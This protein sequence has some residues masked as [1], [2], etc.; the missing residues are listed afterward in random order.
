MHFLLCLYC[1][2]SLDELARLPNDF[3]RKG[4]KPHERE[5]VWRFPSF[6]LLSHMKED[7]LV[8]RIAIGEIPCYLIAQEQCLVGEG[9]HCNLA[10]LLYLPASASFCNLLGH[11][12]IF[13]KKETKP[14]YILSG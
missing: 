14:N 7:D 3:Q 9:P 2:L 1:L 13:L 8:A 10:L 12:P 5:T 6:F 11:N 4:A